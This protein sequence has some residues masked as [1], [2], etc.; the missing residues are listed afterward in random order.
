MSLKRSEQP[1]PDNPATALDIGTLHSRRCHLYSVAIVAGALLWIGGIVSYAG[2]SL[3][4]ERANQFHRYC[5]GKCVCDGGYANAALM[6]RVCPEG[7]Q[8]AYSS[9]RRKLRRHRKLRR[10]RLRKQMQ[11]TPPRPELSSGPNV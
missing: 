5:G 1:T 2:H 8:G 10:E 7:W 6:A 9:A 3:P 11:A 4:K